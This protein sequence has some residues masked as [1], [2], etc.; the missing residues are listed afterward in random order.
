MPT[1]NFISA[2]IRIAELIKDETKM[3]YKVSMDKVSIFLAHK[4]DRLRFFL[5]TYQ[6][7]LNERRFIYTYLPL[8]R[9]CLHLDAVV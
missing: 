4:E 6:G 1:S 3:F 8:L 5:S 7:L 9:F 2:Y